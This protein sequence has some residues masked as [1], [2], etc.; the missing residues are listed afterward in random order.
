MVNK[1][2]QNLHVKFGD[3]EYGWITM[4]LTVDTYTLTVGLSH[5]YDP[6]PD[7][8]AWLEAIIIGVEECGF[9]VDEESS[10]VKFFARKE[11]NSIIKPH[12]FTALSVT[13]DYDVKPLRL[14]L[15]T[16][17]LVKTFYQAFRDFVTSDSYLRE[18]WEHITLKQVLNEQIGM[19]AEAWIDSVI[20]LDSR[21]VQKALWRLDPD[22]TANEE[23]HSE[24]VGNEADLF[25]LT[26]Q[27]KAEAGGLPCYWPLPHELWGLHAKKDEPAQREFL[28]E[29]L[30]DPITSSWDGY[31]WQ[32]MR[33]SMIEQWFDTDSLDS[34]SF[35][36]KWLTE[37]PK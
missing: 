4:N 9:N 14:T 35:W 27:T 19:T 33:S 10:I 18:H 20:L 34:C 2:N 31:P 24:D 13:P 7:M 30:S 1:V 28:C 23:G 36:E 37:Q 8:L 29:R 5:I 12:L 16:R 15:P 11:F 25:E 6:L 22:I 17:E 21:Q 32:K 3:C 26:G